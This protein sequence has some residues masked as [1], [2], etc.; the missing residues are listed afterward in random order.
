MEVDSGAYA[1]TEEALQ[2][3]APAERM[4]A[5]TPPTPA[6]RRYRLAPLPWPVSQ[7]V[8]SPR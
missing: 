4:Q 6:P 5:G 7:A 8:S 2:A 3:L 1:P